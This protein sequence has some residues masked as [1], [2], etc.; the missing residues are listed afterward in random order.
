MPV[1]EMALAEWPEGGGPIVLG[2]TTDPAIVRAVREHLAAR[3]RR[4]LS[5][6][7]GPVRLVPPREDGDEQA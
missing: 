5:R 4:E 6:L 7:E 3:R 2:R 1:L